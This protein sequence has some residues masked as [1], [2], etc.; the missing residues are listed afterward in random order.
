MYNFSQFLF[1]KKKTIVIQKPQ[2]FVF[3]GKSAPKW[4]KKVE[5]K[6]TL[7]QKICSFFR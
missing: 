3:S 2:K 6:K 4:A 7:W 5:A 1:Q